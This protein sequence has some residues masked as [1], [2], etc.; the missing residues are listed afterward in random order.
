MSP[1]YN[2]FNFWKPE[3]PDIES[4]L[5]EFLEVK[6]DVSD[7]KT[8]YSDSPDVKTKDGED[9]EEKEFSTFNFWRDP[10]PLVDLDDLD[11]LD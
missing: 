2:A 11:A 6:M 8:N 7:S 1:D 4:E 9:A 3:L 5:S 10:I